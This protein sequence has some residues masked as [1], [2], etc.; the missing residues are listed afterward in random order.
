MIILKE[1]AFLREAITTASIGIPSEHTKDSLSGQFYG[2]AWLKHD[3][4]EVPFSFNAKTGEIDLTGSPWNWLA[5]ELKNKPYT[6]DQKNFL[7]KHAKDIA[8]FL[9]KNSRC[10]FDGTKWQREK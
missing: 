7:T 8:L 5:K 1:S 9:K 2:Y 3:S 10:Y 4:E 6:A